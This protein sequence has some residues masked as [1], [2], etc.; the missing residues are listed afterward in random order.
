MGLYVEQLT[1]KLL[2]MGTAPDTIL[3]ARHAGSAHDSFAR[4]SVAGWA[5]W[6]YSET[7]RDG[8]RRKKWA[9]RPE[10]AFPPSGS[11]K[12]GGAG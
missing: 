7:E 11:L 10:G 6:T 1:R 2:A 4:L 8:L 5:N 3:L 12:S 9:P